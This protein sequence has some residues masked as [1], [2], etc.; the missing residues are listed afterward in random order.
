MGVGNSI[1]A[2]LS[3]AMNN[4]PGGFY[5]WLLLSTGPRSSAALP[6]PELLKYDCY[7]SLGYGIPKTGKFSIVLTA[8][9]IFVDFPG[10]TCVCFE[11]YTR[12]LPYRIELIN[13]ENVHNYSCNGITGKKI[14]DV[15]IEWACKI[16]KLVRYGFEFKKISKVAGLLVPEWKINYDYWMDLLPPG[17]LTDC[18]K[19]INGH[20]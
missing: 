7:S 8:N 12:S 11:I 14:V 6:T 19:K 17:E 3:T 16:N 9:Y 18:V 4:T 1:C 15:I 2:I 10:R 5:N 20:A 13:I